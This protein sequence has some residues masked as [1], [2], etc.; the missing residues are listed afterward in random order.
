[1]LLSV[2]CGYLWQLS[3][4]RVRFLVLAL[5]L[6]RHE[7]SAD[8]GRGGEFLQRGPGLSCLYFFRL[9]QSGLPVCR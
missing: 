8:E 1:M 3:V 9:M 5:P 7:M 2:A 4:G 6:P